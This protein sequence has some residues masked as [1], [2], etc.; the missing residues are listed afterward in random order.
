MSDVAKDDRTRF[1]QSVRELT[2]KE[3]CDVQPNMVLCAGSMHIRPHPLAHHFQ[4]CSSAVCSARAVSVTL[5]LTDSEGRERAIR[6]M[7]A[8]IRTQTILLQ[9]REGP[10]RGPHLIIN[11]IVKGVVER[12]SDLFFVRL[13]LSPIPSDQKQTRD[14]AEAATHDVEGTRTG[15]RKRMRTVPLEFLGSMRGA[16]LKRIRPRSLCLSQGRR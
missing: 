12:N 4:Q 5:T 15:P 7:S 6:K 1:H 8:A 3:T 9:G 10:Y 2:R 16:E 11:T 13:A 14:H